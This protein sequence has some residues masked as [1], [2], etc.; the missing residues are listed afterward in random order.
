M[1]D[2][3]RSG[4]DR[5]S[6]DAGF[7]AGERVAVAVE[8]FVLR[9]V[10]FAE[11]AEVFFAGPA[12]DGEVGAGDVGVAQ[13]LGSEVMRGCAEELGPGAVGA[14]GGLEGGDLLFDDFEL[15]DNDEHLRLRLRVQIT[16]YR[17]QVAGCR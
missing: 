7:A 11:G 6:A 17:L 5:V 9:V 14:V 1:N 15:P 10:V 12:V 4:S 2:Y 8:G 13:E 16:G 3:E